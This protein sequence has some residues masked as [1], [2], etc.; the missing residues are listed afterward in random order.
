[1]GG[2]GGGG[3]STNVYTERLR[4]EVQPLSLLNTIFHEKGNP[5]VYLLTRNKICYQ[6]EGKAI[7]AGFKTQNFPAHFQA[8]TG[9][10]LRSA[11]Y[12]PVNLHSSPAT[13]IL[14]EP[15]CDKCK[16]L[17]KSSFGYLKSKCLP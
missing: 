14:N 7:S 4:P 9:K 1:M 11:K 13:T 2:E 6:T 12:S 5:F 3:Y 15:P 8:H 17:D 16:D 10:G